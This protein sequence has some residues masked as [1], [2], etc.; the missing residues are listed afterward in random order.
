M[1]YFDLK[2]FKFKH[3]V[4]AEIPE[5][6]AAASTADAFVFLF[7]GSLV[8]PGGMS[9]MGTRV[10]C[11]L[12]QHIEGAVP[13]FRRRGIV[14]KAGDDNTWNAMAPKSRIVII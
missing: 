9:S 8:S 2:L 7:V 14:T 5:I 6:L 13:I 1:E 12:L 4:V 11:L 3:D 10:I